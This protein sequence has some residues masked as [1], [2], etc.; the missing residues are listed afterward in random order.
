MII[1][2]KQYKLRIG[3]QQKGFLP[4]LFGILSICITISASGQSVQHF[5]YLDQSGKEVS[6][7]QFRGKVV[8]ID[9]WA[10]WCAPCREEFPYSK[11]LLKKLTAAQREQVVFLY[12]SIDE[13]RDKW[14]KTLSGPQAKGLVEGAHGFS[15][16]GWN[17]EAAKF[18]QIDG[19]PRYVLIDKS[20]E[21]VLHEATR[22]SQQRATLRHITG[23]IGKK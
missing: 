18:F 3:A 14:A 9:F 2:N 11:K 5:R 19:I 1:K 20:G 8:Y 17:S 10:S 22:P 21:I 15:P 6:V 7:A 12:I 23:Q 4:A 16:G 13:D